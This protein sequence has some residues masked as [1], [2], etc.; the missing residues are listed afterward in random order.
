[1]NTT[2]TEQSAPLYQVLA[3]DGTVLGS[4]LR[5]GAAETLVQYLQVQEGR[6]GNANAVTIQPMPQ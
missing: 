4:Y 5:R 3:A 2:M 6:I 1:M